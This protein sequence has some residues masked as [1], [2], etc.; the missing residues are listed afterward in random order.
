MKRYL[1]IAIRIG[2]SLGLLGCAYYLVDPAEV[3]SHASEVSVAQ[4]LA[5]AILYSLGQ[6]ISAVKWRSI[7]A[8]AGARCTLSRTV[9]AYSLGMF[10]NVAAL[11]TVGGD[12]VRSVTI[13]GKEFS[14]A[15]A[16]LAS[17]F[18]RA[19]GL[20]I[21]LGLGGIAAI[22]TAPAPALRFAASLELLLALSVYSAW[23]FAPNAVRLISAMI[24]R[25]SAVSYAALSVLPRRPST[26]LWMTF[27]SLLTH[28]LQISMHAILLS[29]LG[30]EWNWLFLCTVVP[31]V[32][33]ASAM[34]I[35]ING[36]GVREAGYLI[37]F[38]IYGLSPISATAAAG[39]WFVVT[40]LVG[41]FSF[42]ILRMFLDEPLTQARTAY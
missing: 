11:G 39:I 1:K 41:A 4:L 31:I 38:Q 18:D 30:V 8:S 2:V 10:A 33:T 15:K 27:L 24:P 25:A 35:S 16:V 9:Y 3:I 42:P 28:G 6:L 7:L 36:L 37:L 14:T 34:P 19:H 26:V 32:N 40:M 17:A 21:L 12:L 13:S 23:R 29:A 5:I 22:F 20:A